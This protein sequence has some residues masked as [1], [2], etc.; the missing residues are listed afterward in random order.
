MIGTSCQDT[1][2]HDNGECKY[3]SYNETSNPPP[4][5]PPD[6]PEPEDDNDNDERIPGYDL[7]SLFG[8]ICAVS[9][10]L[11]RRRLKLSCQNVGTTSH[12][13]YSDF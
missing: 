12:N 5:P 4:I 2:Y 3:Y 6:D 10:I 1:Y 9:F 13:E 7:F 11:I 8:V